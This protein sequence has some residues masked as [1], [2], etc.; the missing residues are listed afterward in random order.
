MWKL[1]Q[2]ILALL[3][4]AIGVAV[5]TFLSSSY[6]DRGM[7]QTRTIAIS[8]GMTI[9]EIGA[10][11]KKEGLVRSELAFKALSRILGV[12]KEIK[13]G[14]YTIPVGS[15][16]FGIIH[17]LERGMAGED[18]VTIPEGLRADEIA[19]IL[20]ERIGLDNGEFMALVRSPSFARS[21]GV[22]ASCLEGYLFPDTYS[23]FPAMSAEEAARAMVGRF[24]HIF[25]REFARKTESSGFTMHEVVTL[26][27]I[28]EAEAKLS[29]ER[30]KIASVFLERLKKNWKLQADPTVTYALDVKRNRV[31]YSD[32]A[33]DSPF[34]TYIHT[35]LPP[36]PICSP[37][38][39][40]LRAVLYP[41]KGSR[42]MYFVARGDG[43]HIFSSSL[44]EH[45]SAIRAVKGSGH[46]DSTFSL[47]DT[48]MS[49]TPIGKK[50]H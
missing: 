39:A 29:E 30:P 33:V 10:L 42:D 32:L 5:T 34:N 26:G 40:S 1:R 23:F 43:S 36:G 17:S 15:S 49:S 24:F 22:P 38:R 35:G 6:L 2:V 28:V 47:P 16:V 31:Y 19:D 3:L 8:R 12:E 37:G 27:S 7:T 14:F 21:V 9:D 48:S 46:P 25:E 41:S 18:L 20:S 11:L 45:L 44:E 4:A 13:A 50:H